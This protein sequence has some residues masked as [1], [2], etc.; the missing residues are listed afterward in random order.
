MPGTG[1][2]AQ[3]NTLYDVTSVAGGIQECDVLLPWQPYQD[4]KALLMSLIQQPARRD[5]VHSYGVDPVACHL[6]EI[7]GH[8]VPIRIIAPAL[9]RLKRAVGDS[10]DVEFLL[11]K[12]QELTADYRSSCGDSNR[13]IVL[14]FGR[15]WESPASLGI[16]WSW[17]LIVYLT[18]R[19]T[20]PSPPYYLNERFL[21]REPYY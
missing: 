11:S 16:Y 18:Q 1:T 4:I 15:R 19:F 20:Q 7:A 17:N 8:H 6:A 21:L 13:I 3:A 12:A 14:G 5:C 10:P 2:H 9:I